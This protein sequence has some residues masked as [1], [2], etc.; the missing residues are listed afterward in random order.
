MRGTMG[1]MAKL[2]RISQL[3]NQGMPLKEAMAQSSYEK[4]KAL[5]SL[6]VDINAK[7]RDVQALIVDICDQNTLSR[8]SRVLAKLRQQRRNVETKL[9]GE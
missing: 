5:V 1:G 4:R 3:L 2:H 6:L 9:R 7:V 8:A